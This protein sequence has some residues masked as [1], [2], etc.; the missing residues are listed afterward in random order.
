MSAEMRRQRGGLRRPRTGQLCMLD[1]AQTADATFGAQR[2]SAIH[3]DGRDGGRGTDRGRRRPCHPHGGGTAGRTCAEVR[4]RCR[5]GGTGGRPHRL[6]GD[7]RHPDAARADRA[8]LPG[9]L[10]GRSRPA[11]N[12]GH[13]RIVGRVHSGVSGA[14]RARRPGRGGAAGLSA[15]PQYPVGAR[16]RAGDDRDHAGRRAGRSRPRCCSPNIARSRCKA[17]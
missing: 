1:A 8:T 5:A 11:S 14:V 15:L 7:A 2:C 10:R 17:C 16:L 9:N 13:H 6:Y 3:G 4:D 12:R